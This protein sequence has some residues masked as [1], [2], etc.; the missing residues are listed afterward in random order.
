VNI[1]TL[2]SLF[3]S[4]LMGNKAASLSPTES[5]QDLLDGNIA[6]RKCSCEE[7]ATHLGIVVVLASHVAFGDIVLNKQQN[8]DLIRVSDIIIKMLDDIHSGTVN[9]PHL[10]LCQEKALQALLRLLVIPQFAKKTFDHSVTS[11]MNHTSTSSVRVFTLAFIAFFN[12][13][14]FIDEEASVI[15]GLR[16]G[17][18]E[19]ESSRNSV[20]ILMDKIGVYPRLMHF[21]TQ[22][23]ARDDDDNMVL[24]SILIFRLL[25]WILT[26]TSNV[27]FS[28]RFKLRQILL[29]HQD[30]LFELTR[31]KSSSLS[32]VAISMV[33]LLLR[34]EEPSTC[35]A[36]QVHTNNIIIYVSNLI[37]FMVTGRGPWLW[38]LAMDLSSARVTH[39]RSHDRTEKS[40]PRATTASSASSAL[41]T[42]RRLVQYRWS[43]VSIR[44]YRE[45][46]CCCG[47]VA[48]G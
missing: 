8:K 19:Q 43:G 17:M 41:A 12:G 48:R 23:S 47:R 33:V 44:R 39:F 30:T 4:P 5:I 11:I 13:F 37:G 42:T 7:V 2:L 32:D 18:S 31:H 10:A 45:R 34:L 21:L 26:R 22:T 1:N 46:I 14:R 29:Q 15:S 24:T 40:R 16:Q 3:H 27:T 6:L 38:G 20:C 28:L 36:M 35:M 9:D 25:S